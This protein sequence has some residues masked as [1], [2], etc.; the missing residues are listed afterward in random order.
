MTSDWTELVTVNAP[1]I[2]YFEA[3]YVLAAFI[4]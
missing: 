3:V 2:Y 4:L 1:N